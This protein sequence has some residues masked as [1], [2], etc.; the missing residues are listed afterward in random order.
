MQ[1]QCS[2]GHSDYVRRD[3]ALAALIQPL[4]GEYGMHNNAPQGASPPPK[5]PRPA[6]TLA[7]VHAPACA[8][9]PSLWFCPDRVLRISRQNFRLSA[10]PEVAVGLAA[11]KF[12]MSWGNQ[13]AQQ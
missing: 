5:E 3:A 2:I 9:W 10:E 4:A 12:R 11:L 8:Q 1:V 13:D 7:D 6:R